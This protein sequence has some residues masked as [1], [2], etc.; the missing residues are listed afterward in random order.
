MQK[1][2]VQS[3]G[4][5]EGSDNPLQY[6]CLENLMDRG[7]W[8]ATVLGSQRVRHDWATNT[9]VFFSC[10]DRLPLGAGK[11]NLDPNP[12]AWSPC[13]QGCPNRGWRWLQPGSQALWEPAA[14]DHM[15]HPIWAAAGGWD[16][17]NIGTSEKSSS[18]GEKEWKEFRFP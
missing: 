1:T 13:R 9:F 5:E 3:L 17:D 18:V 16:A 2:Q 12:P 10:I 7:A 6:S 4:W 8:Q 15:S 14:G 11:G